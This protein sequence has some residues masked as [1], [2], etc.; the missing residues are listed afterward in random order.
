MLIRVERRFSFGVKKFSTRS[1]QFEP[2]VLINFAFVPTINSGESFKYLGHLFNFEMD[3]TDQNDL[4]SSSIQSMLKAVDSGRI[5]PRNKLFRYA[6]SWHFTYLAYPK[7]GY[8][9]I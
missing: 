9:N 2:K 4:L 1:F 5:H 7:F 6:L 8:L 3:N